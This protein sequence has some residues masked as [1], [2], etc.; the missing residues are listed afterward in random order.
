[1]NQPTAGHEVWSVILAAGEVSPHFG[2]RSRI[3]LAGM[4][5][6]TVGP[7]PQHLVSTEVESNAH[8]KGQSIKPGR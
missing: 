7:R 4:D 5:H 8:K 1:M 3:R 6:E 2:L